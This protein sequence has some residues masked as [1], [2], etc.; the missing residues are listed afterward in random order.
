M[1]H[2]ESLPHSQS[3]PQHASSLGLTVWSRVPQWR[4]TGLRPWAE[5]CASSCPPVQLEE[6]G[7]LAAAA[8][9]TRASLAD[10]MATAGEL[11]AAIQAGGL[12]AQAASV[13]DDHLEAG[14]V[15]GSSHSMAKP[16]LPQE[17]GEGLLGLVCAAWESSCC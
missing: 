9:A 11:A 4:R 2:L 5:S 10:L 12:P 8:R 7:G 15:P 1:P 13:P 16:E 3:M 6:L 14:Q 17:S